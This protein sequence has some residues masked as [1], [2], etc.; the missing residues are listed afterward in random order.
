MVVDSIFCVIL[1]VGEI[2]Q[3]PW[4]LDFIISL[5]LLNYSIIDINILVDSTIINATTNKLP[6]HWELGRINICYR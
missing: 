4:L 3:M 1:L 2:W 5:Y 6:L